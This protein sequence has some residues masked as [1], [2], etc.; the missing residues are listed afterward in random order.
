MWRAL[1]S[2][3]HW[4][5]E[6]WNRRKNGEV[7][8]ELLTISVI[9][10]EDGEA[11]GYVALFYDISQIKEQQQQLEHLAHFDALTGLPN[12]TLL[13]DRLQQAMRHAERRHT[14]VAV[15]YLDI[16]G[17]KAINDAYGHAIGDKLLVAQAGRLNQGLREGDTLARL[18]GDEFV[19]VLPDLAD[20]DIAVPII[21]RLLL[22]AA[23]SLPIEG[24]LL[25]ASAS[26]GVSFYPQ[27]EGVDADQ[28]LRQADQAMYC[29]KQSGKNRFHLFD[30]EQDRLLRGRHEGI[31]HIRAALENGELALFYQPKVNL[32]SGAV[33]GF[34][35]LIRWQHPERGLIPP[36]QFLPL[37]EGHDLIVALG[38]WTIENALLQMEIWHK[39][40]HVLP[41][42]VNVAGRQ[43]QTP[44]F[45]DK[46][47]AAL[48]LHPAVATQL[49]LEVLENSALDDMAY[50]AQIIASCKML[51]VGFALDDFGA[52]YSSLTYLRCLPAQ[53]LKIDQS[54]V[55]EMLEATDD[56]VIL[57]GIV[58]LAESFGRH[59]IA[60]GVETP[61]H[62]EMLLRLGCE[63][64][65]GYA[66]A[67]PMP[68]AAVLPWL[69]SWNPSDLCRKFARV[70]RSQ[71]PVLQGMVEI[72]AWVA[73]LRRH[74]HDAT[75]DAP[76]LDHMS[77][78]FS[79]WLT[80][81]GNA[82][83]ANSEA[84]GRIQD[85][86]EALHRRAA[87]LLE[88]GRAGRSVEALARFHE[89]ETCREALIDALQGLL[90]RQD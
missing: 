70:D 35:A 62:G 60:E 76:P 29:A 65:Q 74:L 15:I 90:E 66:I 63:F 23:E 88:F 4:S 71:M 49:E 24:L 33:I 61:A 28:L 17:F 56:L 79:T 52:G 43:L 40:G 16:D 10:N 72:G 19:V 68:A 50:V 32:R 5:G 81:S 25:R 67:R 84:A 44:E 2:N 20:C 73:S 13:A 46:L 7:Y 11:E 9:K 8:P 77:C 22:A 18:G 69:E 45:L 30:A 64:A 39:H 87:E 42:S 12:R 54:F 6:I 57:E 89:I 3:G 47:K 34:E 1:E 82:H 78:H 21:Q 75:A 31:G 55:R 53:T 14:H 85:L 48:S 83:L 41:V 51:G 36:A 27:A 37:I 59:V 80:S 38:D 58:V 86:H 26:I